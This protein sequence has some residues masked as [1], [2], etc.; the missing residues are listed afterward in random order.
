MLWHVGSFNGMLDFVFLQVTS[1]GEANQEENGRSR[2]ELSTNE[3]ANPK[4]E[5]E[6]LEQSDLPT[7]HISK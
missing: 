7:Q 4:I 1:G 6:Q 3:Q 5:L 2:N